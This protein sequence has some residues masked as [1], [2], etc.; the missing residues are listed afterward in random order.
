MKKLIG[1]LLMVPII[2]FAQEEPKKHTG[3][4]IDK[5]IGVA[6]NEVLLLSELETA[7]L[8]ATQGKGNV[9]KAQRA[10]IFENLMYEK[11][12]LNQAK[13]DS[14]E[15]TDAEVNMQVARRLDYF[16]QMFGSV[17]EFEK[18]YGKTQAQLKDEYF[19]M[20]KDQLLVQRMEEQIT[21][22]VKVTPSDIQKY[23]NSVPADSLPLIGEQIQY[24]K[25]E[26]APKIRESEKQ[27]VIHFLDSIRNRLVSGLSTMTLEAA[28]WSED[29]GSKYK[30][31]CY[32]MQRKGSFVPE[33]EAAVANTPEGTYSP[34]F[35]SMYGYH[36]VK[37]VEKRGEFYESCHILM[38]PK[39]LPEDLDAARTTLEKIL[40]YLRNDS[41]T[42]T[43]AVLRY[44]TDE[45]TKNQFGRVINPATLG[46]KHD[47]SGLSP[48]MNLVLMNMK[49]GDISEPTLI[50][51]FDGKQ[52]YA[53]FRLDERTPAHRA[54]LKDDYEIFKSVAEQEVK[55]KETD[56]WV[57]KKIAETYIKVDEEF[58]DGPFE[59]PWVKSNP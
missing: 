12:L 50:T 38:S 30:G 18:Y 51:G 48:E 32:P 33:Y 22:N 17:E 59:F 15:V 43:D 14:I 44:S 58:A 16:V 31:G 10:E 3:Q 47:V 54:N 7:I 29:P 55:R 23:Y 26:V 46:T 56:K 36:I 41:I 9:T 1:L 49:K 27:K 42:F 28:K 5:I 34:V 40:Y 25:L 53:I 52:S 20:I 2:A 19:D 35:S 8:Q 11:L 4:V 13:V 24:S 57:K 37:V 21:K 39:T 45:E 6:G